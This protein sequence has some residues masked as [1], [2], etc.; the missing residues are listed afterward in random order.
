MENSENVNFGFVI[1][2]RKCIGCHACTVACKSEH[3]VAIGVNRTHVKY[4]EKGEYPNSTREFSVHRC[5]HC[6]DA[7]CVEICPTIALFTRKDGIVDFDNARCIG[8]RSCMQAC[9]YDALYIDPNTHTAAKCNY[10]AHR[11]E[12]S[13]EPACVVVCPV[14]AIISGDLNNPA[15]K[16][17]QLIKDQ[18]VKVRKPEKRTKPNVY[19][20][21]T[22]D[23]ILHPTQPDRSAQYAWSEQARGVGHFAKFAQDKLSNHDP[24]KLILQLALEK[25][26]RSANP[27]DQRVI[28]D[29]LSHIAE[30]Q[31]GQSK[32]VYDAPAK[33]VL[34]GWQLPAYIWT[35]A[36]ASGLLMVAYTLGLTGLELTQNQ[37]LSIHVSAL[38]FLAATGALLVGDLDRPDRFLYVLLRPNWSSWLVKGA[39]II[40]GFGLLG[41]IMLGLSF[42]QI[43]APKWLMIGGII[44]AAAT[45]I[46]TAFL[47]AQAKAR[48]L[49]SS[50]LSPLHMLVHAIVAGSAAL[51][52]LVPSAH[53]SWRPV[54]LIS[55][56]ANI[57]LVSLEA[58]MK[59]K[60]DDANLAASK[61]TRGRY[62]KYFYAGLL[63]GGVLPL[64]LLLIPLPLAAQII[65]AGLALAGIYLNEFVR[66]RAPQLISLS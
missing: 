58:F 30:D 34:W 32:R 18:E 23:E 11:I 54:L 45:A 47:L 2:N 48:D 26:A 5:N 28:A 36:I 55:V 12:A 6:E 38:V 62:A 53:A 31:A 29:V 35:K 49:W 61:M 64:C 40:T 7:P 21:D 33:G 43:E 22:S 19:Y 63:G 66:I 9:P 52:F 27:Q 14:E 4:I 59:H 8:C 10:C 65:A 25:Q 17:S 44:L 16:I 1:D 20:V 46:Y 3:D 15:S 39:Y 57:V 13:Y 24:D 41:T 60:T 51:Y 42:L 37:Q 50:A 56:F